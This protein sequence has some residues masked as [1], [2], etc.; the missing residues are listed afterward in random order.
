MEGFK[1]NS[2]KYFIKNKNFN[3]TFLDDRRQQNL[4]L[5]HTKSHVDLSIF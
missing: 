2:I 1:L 5:T 4:K 3:K